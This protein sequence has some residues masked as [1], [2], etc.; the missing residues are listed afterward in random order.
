MRFM[1]DMSIQEVATTLGR[2][3]GSVK[4]LQH[5]GLQSLARRLQPMVVHP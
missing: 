4:A 5:R 2:T 3:E 1:A